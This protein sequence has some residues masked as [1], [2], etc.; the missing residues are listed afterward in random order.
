M[1]KIDECT[2]YL[3]CLSHYVLA[4]DDARAVKLLSGQAALSSLH[5]SGVSVFGER[6][7]YFLTTL[8]VYFGD[9]HDLNAAQNPPVVLFHDKFKIV[10]GEAWLEKV[11]PSEAING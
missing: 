8:H 10:T 5:V 1:T 7:I 4:Q 2:S 3:G 11:N 6:F 9:A